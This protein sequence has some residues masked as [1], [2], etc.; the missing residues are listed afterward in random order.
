MQREETKRVALKIRRTDSQRKE[1]KS[2]AALLKTVNSVNVGPKFIA[3]KL[4][5][6]L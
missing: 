4:R 1:M 5:T 2:E 3:C 6:F